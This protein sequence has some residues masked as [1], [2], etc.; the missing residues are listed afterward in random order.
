MV[1]KLDD[2]TLQDAH[3]LLHPIRYR[4]VKLLAEKPMHINEIAKTLGEERR[5]V[6]YHLRILEDYGFVSSKY[7]ISEEERSKGKAQKIFSVTNKVDQTII[8]MK[9]EL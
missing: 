2:K 7:V 3:I 4:E 8:S 9:R 6:G 5:L 1:V